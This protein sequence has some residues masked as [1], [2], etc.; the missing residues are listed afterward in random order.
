M[1]TYF[2]SISLAE[3]KCSSSKAAAVLGTVVVRYCTVIVHYTVQQKS[4]KLLQ[5]A[6]QQ[7]P[8]KSLFPKSYHHITRLLNS[9]L[10]NILLIMIN[11]KFYVVAEGVFIDS[12][13]SMCR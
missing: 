2:Y 7:M 1:C 10:K 11:V 3:S 8:I 5:S 6:A 12:K 4:T 13:I 9:L